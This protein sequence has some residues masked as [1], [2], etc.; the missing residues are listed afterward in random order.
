MSLKIHIVISLGLLLLGSVSA[1]SQCKLI[2]GEKGAVYLNFE[3]TAMVSVD[4]SDQKV[5]GTIF[6]IHNN[7]SCPILL[8]TGDATAFYKPLPTNPTAMQRVKRE[9]DWV[10]PEGAMV[11]YLQYRY[12]SRKSNGNSVGGDQLFGFE[13]V[14]GRFVRFEV[15][16]T[17]LD[18]T[19]ANE[20]NVEFDYGWETDNKDRVKRSNVVNRVRYFVSSLPLEV[21]KEIREFLG[22]T[23]PPVYLRKSSAFP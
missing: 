3:K 8:T 10:L 16:F 18:P 11:P 12:Q 23:A 1:S 4:G 21:Q 5:K 20:L 13:L 9:I 7:S 22:I 2:D 19:F 6:Q 14:A 17:H 15:P